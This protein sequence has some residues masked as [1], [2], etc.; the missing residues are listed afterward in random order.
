MLS[1]TPV[2]ASFLSSLSKLFCVTV[3][4][5]WQIPYQWANLK[6]PKNLAI[7]D[8]LVINPLK[9]LKIKLFN[10]ILAV[11]LNLK[12][13]V[14]LVSWLG[15]NKKLWLK[16]YFCPFWSFFPQIVCFLNKGTLFKN[17]IHYI[18]ITNFNC[19]MKILDIVKIQFRQSC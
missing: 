14:F 11:I 4:S 18:R 7:N 1:Q 16:L 8:K 15:D 9:L 19:I 5:R 6:G 10:S 13:K 12:N 17:N 2:A 3:D